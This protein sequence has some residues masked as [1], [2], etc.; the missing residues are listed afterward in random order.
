[1]KPTLWFF[2]LVLACGSLTA[3]EKSPVQTLLEVTRYEQTA[4]DSA[5]AAFDGMIDQLKQ[6]GVPDAAVEEIRAEARALY[7]RIFTADELRKQTVELYT[8]HFTEE[9]IVELT[10]F[11]RTPLGQKTLAATPAIMTDVMKVAMPAIQK[12]MP[13]FQQKVGEIVEKHQAP[14]DGG[15]GAEDAE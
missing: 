13:A 7:V 10:E 5:L 14:A 9:E 6:Q 11:Y 15:E 8:K 3:Q 4:I 2:S 12:E 1:M